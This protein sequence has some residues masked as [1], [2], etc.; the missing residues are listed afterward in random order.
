MT[1]PLARLQV[2]LR[3]RAHLALV[4]RKRLPTFLGEP[5]LVGKGNGRLARV[6]GACREDIERI[7]A[8]R[9]I[10]GICRAI[11][12]IE[13]IAVE[14]HERLL[15]AVNARRPR[16]RARPNVLVLLVE[17][18]RRGAIPHVFDLL[19]VVIQIL[20]LL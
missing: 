8:Q 16:L 19:P 20:K 7:R 18:D 15:H 11:L 3:K 2:A 10:A 6:V 12:K 14:A 9:G 4:H 17:H 13:L 5:E 1:Q